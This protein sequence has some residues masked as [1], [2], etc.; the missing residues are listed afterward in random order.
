MLRHSESAATLPWSMGREYRERM[1]EKA[2]FFAA[3]RRS[4]S[5]QTSLRVGNYLDSK[6][7]G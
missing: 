5:R 7:S 6:P 4:V 1:S 3:E 2:G